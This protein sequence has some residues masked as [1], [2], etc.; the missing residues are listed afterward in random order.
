[1]QLESQILP[2]ISDVLFPNNIYSLGIQLVATFL[3]FSRMPKFPVVYKNVYSFNMH[4]V[5]RK[6]RYNLLVR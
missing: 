4:I 1:M 6:A 2:I 5:A 3:P